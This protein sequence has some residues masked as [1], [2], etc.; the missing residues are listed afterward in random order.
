MIKA[1]A[2][3]IERCDNPSK[4][5]LVEFLRCCDVY[6]TLNERE[7]YV[8]FDDRVPIINFEALDS[9]FTAVLIHPDHGKWC[10]PVIGK[11][12]NNP[13]AAQ[14]LWFCALKRCNADIDPIEPSPAVK[15]WKT[16]YG[17]GYS[18]GYPGETSEPTNKQR[19]KPNPN[20]TNAAYKAAEAFHAHMEEMMRAYAR[21][22]TPRK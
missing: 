1:A 5:S 9:L 21:Q 4:R 14:A 6:S 11:H 10:M 18:Y 13:I 19:S 16:Y 2:H 3:W 12:R 7:A 15:G 8:K 17:Y 20:Y 22:N